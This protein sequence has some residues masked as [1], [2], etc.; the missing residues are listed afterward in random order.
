MFSVDTLKNALSEFQCRDN[1]RVLVQYKYE[2]VQKN[3]SFLKLDFRTYY[4]FYLVM[5]LL[6]V[7]I[8]YSRL[9]NDCTTFYILYYIYF[10]STT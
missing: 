1:S 9:A 10:T 5:S 7:I 6:C 2:E 8:I 3:L 4:S